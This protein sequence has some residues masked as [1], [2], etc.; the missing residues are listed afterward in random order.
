MKSPLQKRFILIGVILSASVLTACTVSVAGGLGGIGVTLLLALV[1]FMTAGTQAGC[2]EP[3]V[4]PCLSPP[5]DWDLGEDASADMQDDVY[6]GPCLSPLPPDM[7]EDMPIGPCLSIAPED[8]GSDMEDADMD[9]DAD[10]ALAPVQGVNS[11][12]TDRDRILAKLGQNL[13]EDVQTR[14]NRKA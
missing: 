3:D 10:M 7:G 9:E 2:D 4:G 14:L 11:G 1:V 5:I 6:V 13:P 12:I 8:M